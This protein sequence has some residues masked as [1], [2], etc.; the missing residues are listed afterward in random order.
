[1]AQQRKAIQTTETPRTTANGQPACKATN[2]DGALCRAFAVGEDGYCWGHDPK[3]REEAQAAR[4]EGARTKNHLGRLRRLSARLT[5]NEDLMRFS[6]AVITDLF[7]GRVSDQVAR[8]VLY[9]VSV[10]RALIESAS[11]ERNRAAQRKGAKQDQHEEDGA[12]LRLV[13]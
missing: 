10:Q 7:Q 8:A 3:R 6:S 12:G 9:G 4:S 1:M 5:T 2:K 13:S 11:I